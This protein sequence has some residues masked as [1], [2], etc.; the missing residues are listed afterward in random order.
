MK[1][2]VLVR[3]VQS[4]ASGRWFSSSHTSAETNQVMEWKDIGRSGG[5]GGQWIAY[6]SLETELVRT[7]TLA[8][9]SPA[10]RDEGPE[11]VLQSEPWLS[12][13]QSWW[14]SSLTSVTPLPWDSPTLPPLRGH[15]SLGVTDSLLSSHRLVKAVTSSL[16]LLHPLCHPLFLFHFP[17]LPWGCRSTCLPYISVILGLDFL[18]SLRAI[19]DGGVIMCPFLWP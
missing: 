8:L 5:V 3:P 4:A 19:I 12:G 6:L 15:C 2:G 10:V 14:S 9:A 13:S 1:L 16:S 18:S 11:T 17:P 7:D